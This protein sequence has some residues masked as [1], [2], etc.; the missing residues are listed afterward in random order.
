[1]RQVRR[2]LGVATGMEAIEKLVD[3]IEVEAQKPGKAE[4]FTSLIGD[5]V[6]EGLKRLARVAYIRFASV[7]RDFADIDN[8]HKEIESLTL[9][10]EARTP[11]AQLPLM[12]EEAATYQ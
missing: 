6:M 1:M 3:E 7:Y 5:M 10:R 8:F 4:V 9:N 11:S 12:P 2:P